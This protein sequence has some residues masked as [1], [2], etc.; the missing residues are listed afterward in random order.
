MIAAAGVLDRGY[1]CY[2]PSRSLRLRDTSFRPRATA[3]L[4]RTWEQRTDRCKRQEAQSGHSDNKTTNEKRTPITLL[5]GCVH[6]SISDSAETKIRLDFNHTE[7]Y[8]APH[9]ALH[10]RCSWA[11]AGLNI[12]AEVRHQLPSQSSIFANNPR[13][14]PTEFPDQ[15]PAKSPLSALSWLRLVALSASSTRPSASSRP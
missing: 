9:A 1:C 4:Y 5:C 12:W 14:P 11:K 2:S 7:P 10:D 6:V 15:L 13:D 8:G 3:V